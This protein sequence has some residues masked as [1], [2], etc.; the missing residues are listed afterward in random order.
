MKLTYLSMLV[1]IAT[2]GAVWKHDRKIV[3][4]ETCRFNALEYSN[5]HS[6][7]ISVLLELL[8]LNILLL[9]LQA[10]CLSLLA[11]NPIQLNRRLW[12]LLQIYTSMF[13]NQVHDQNPYQTDARKGMRR[14]ETSKCISMKKK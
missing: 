8:Q 13:P 7:S 14:K 6:R 1:S 10:A 12:R 11:P 9:D 5:L 2:Q 4:H 3:V